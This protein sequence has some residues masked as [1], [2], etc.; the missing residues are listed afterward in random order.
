VTVTKAT[1]NLSIQGVSDGE[2]NTEG[3]FI[4]VN[5]NFDEANKDGDGDPVPDNQP[6]NSQGDR[7]VAG[8][9]D[10]RI[11]TLSFGSDSTSG[12]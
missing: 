4:P 5:Q 8:D 11:A 1:L 9:S 6:D 12:T 7:I 10:L 2:K 3:A